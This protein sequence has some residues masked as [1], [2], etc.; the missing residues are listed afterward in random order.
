MESFRQ[1]AILIGV[2]RVDKTHYEHSHEIGG[3]KLNVESFE[4]YLLNVANYSKN[5]IHKFHD[6]EASWSNI[7]N[8]IAYY[9]RRSYEE[10]LAILVYF[11]GHGYNLPE[12]FWYK[13]KPSQFF[14]FYDKMI[15]DKQ[16]NEAFSGFSAQTNICWLIDACYSSGIVEY[17]LESLNKSDNIGKFYLDSDR[18]DESMK[19]TI[20]FNKFENYRRVLKKYKDTIY[21]FKSNVLTLTASS[22][23]EAAIPDG[24]SNLTHYTADVLSIVN[25]KFDGNYYYFHETLRTLVKEENQ[26]EIYPKKELIQL[27]HF[28]NHVPFTNIKANLN[29]NFKMG[30][31]QI[32][33]DQ[34]F[35]GDMITGNIE[36]TENYKRNGEIITYPHP[37]IP[38]PSIVEAEMIDGIEY[39]MVI[40]C[41][42][43]GNSNK[44]LIT[45]DNSKLES[46][47]PEGTSNGLVLALNTNGTLKLGSEPTKGSVK[48]KLG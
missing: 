47:D 4:S 46:V 41:A 27:E 36:F 25:S 21:E 3:A 48:N 40:N 19:S 42:P 12:E 32:N 33:L 39:V 28:Y 16:F 38:T 31:K 37:S 15:L 7:E 11:S 18:I 10:K 20:T 29:T 44:I 30:F 35:K 13:N 24:H 1:I 5:A 14:Y 2:N 17:V 34:E 43:G 23:N 26:P 45:K 22:E 6:G 9:E 8:T